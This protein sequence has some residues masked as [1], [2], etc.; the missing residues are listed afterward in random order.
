MYAELFGSVTAGRVLLFVARHGEA[1]TREIA[2][3]FG[4]SPQM[5]HE[6]LRKFERAGLMSSRRLGNLRL[7]RLDP[8]H[9]LAEELRGLLEKALEALPEDARASID[10]K[11]G[12]AKAQEEAGQEPDRSEKSSEP[13]RLDE[14]LRRM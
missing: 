4:I 6:Q 11:A 9:P 7:F 5:A 10:R 1:Y 2:T 8:T 13:D 14:F 3:S 12:G